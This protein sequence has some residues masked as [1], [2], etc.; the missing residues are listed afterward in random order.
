MDI[1][2]YRIK[3][4]LANGPW[5]IMSL[6]YGTMTLGRSPECDITL[7]NPNIS[8]KHVELE[9]AKRLA[10]SGREYL[11]KDEK[12]SIKEHVTNLISLRIPATPNLYDVVWNVE[13]A[14]LLFFSTVK[15]AN[16]ALET[17]FLQSFGLPLIRLFPFTFF[18]LACG[19]SDKD[20][21][22]LKQ[23]KPTPFI[24]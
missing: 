4:A 2:Q 16:E 21:D 14:T 18:E 10:K 7:S 13:A 20:R 6:N 19:L 11:S 3:Y 15:S 5:E 9:I 17:L 12:A 24:E 23:L 22:E 8:R 1:T